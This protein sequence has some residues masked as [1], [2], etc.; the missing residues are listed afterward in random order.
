MLYGLEPRLATHVSKFIYDTVS[1]DSRV[2]EYR[3]TINSK[4]SFFIDFETKYIGDIQKFMFESMEEL[5]ASCIE[6]SNPVF[7][8]GDLVIVSWG[9][10]C[11]IVC[12]SIDQHQIVPDTVLSI[13][14]NEINT[15]NVKFTKYLPMFHHLKK[16]EIRYGSDSQRLSST[17]SDSTQSN[18]Q[19]FDEINNY[20][21]AETIKV[22]TSTLKS[23]SLY[24]VSYTVLPSV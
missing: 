17:Q 7:Y 4:K 22:N 8:I 12:S 23:L 19:M 16:I 10:S 3:R 13:K 14:V 6:G 9:Q 11:D 5:N 18:I 15:K 20:W 2:Q 21:V 24:S 1:E